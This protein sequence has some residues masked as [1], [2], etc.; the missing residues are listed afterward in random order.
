MDPHLFIHIGLPKSGSSFLQQQIFPVLE[1]KGQLNFLNVQKVFDVA[2]RIVYQDPFTYDPEAVRALIAPHL[3]PGINVLTV[4]WFSGIIGYKSF[5][6]LETAKRLWET[7]PDATIMLILRNQVDFAYSAYKQHVHQGG[8]LSLADYFN[9]KEGQIATGFDHENFRFDDHRIYWNSLL[10]SHLIKSYS[11]F[12]ENSRL[13]IFLFENFLKSPED[14]TKEFLSAMGLQAELGQF[15]FRP[16]NLGYGK[17]QIKI[18]RV[19]NRFVHSPY[20]QIGIKPIPWFGKYGTLQAVHI[21][22]ILQSSWSFKLLGNASIRNQDMDACI[23][24]FFNEDNFSI[25]HLI[26]AGDQLLFQKRYLNDKENNS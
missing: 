10:Y 24:K 18:A 5:N 23:S 12:L 15:D 3:R 7:F 19:L 14:F 6:T 22:R 13:K 8:A 4:E 16:I 17:T 11:P 2:A 26:S 9:F 1:K 21:R 25:R 20:N